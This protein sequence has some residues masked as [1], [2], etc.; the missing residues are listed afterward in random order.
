MIAPTTAIAVLITTLVALG[1]L[2]TDFYL[3]ALPAIT[4]ALGTDVGSTQMT[5]SVFLAG[6]GV[7]QLAYG[8]LSDRFGRRPVL[9]VGLVIY[10]L[11]SIACTLAPAIE[12]LIA[13][14]F[15]QALGA[16]AGPV[17]GRAIVRDIYGPQDSARILSYMGAAM[18][19]APLLGPVL[20]G[21]LT[22]WFGW[23]S[24]FVFLTL[25][26]LIQSVLVWRMLDETNTQ[27]DPGALR[28]SQILDNFKTLMGD[29]LYRGVLLCNA[30]IYAGLF[31]F[32][33]G[34]PFVF[35]N[36]FGFSPQTMGLA[37][38]VMVSG[39]IVG[40]TISGRL[41]R[42]YGAH[43]LLFV[44]AVLGA[45]AGVT[46]LMLALAG[47]EHPVSVMGPMV[48]FSCSL[49]LVMPNATA[50]GLAPYP[51]MAGAAASLMG[52]VQMSL[53]AL[54]GTLVGHSLNGSV[55]PMVL[56]IVAGGVCCLL[57]YLLWVRPDAL[58]PA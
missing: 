33:S 55:L 58:A 3:P 46:M 30:F 57:S 29:R 23:R 18:A 41:S 36:I 7:G 4:L 38:G 49:G 32:I 40:T 37:F 45:L 35:I 24:T 54:V 48:F 39:Y 50:M 25:F 5:L 51:K 44:G 19:L 13:A 16:C 8:P 17:L 53:S 21:T 10:V 27:R 34:S 22:V 12:T 20:G 2:S 31:S 47:W 56:G 43:R 14:R 26:S 11:A 1:P 28:P 15:L 9:M 52:F 42:R 6:F